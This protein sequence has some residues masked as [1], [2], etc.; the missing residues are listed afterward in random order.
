M[1]EGRVWQEAQGTGPASPAKECELNLT[2]Q[3][4]SLV[5]FEPGCDM[6]RSVV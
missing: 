1:L 3:W 5:S 2:D 4:K 6:N